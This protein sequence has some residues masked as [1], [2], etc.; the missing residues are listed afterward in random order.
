[1]MNAKMI[2]N[3]ELNGIEVSF[4][5]K[6]EAATLE[7]LKGAGFRWH[8]VK[9]VWYAKNTAERLAIAQQITGED[10]PEAPKAKK[11]TKA[12]TINL[13]NLGENT[14]SL[15]GADLAKAIRED[16]KKRGVTGVTVRARKVT[17][18]TG[19][20]VTI[21]AGAE[22]IASIEEYQ[23]RY[24]YSAFAC[25][26]E[27]SQGVFDGS[28]WIYSNTWEQMTEEER[29]AAYD[30]HTRYYLEKSPSFNQYHQERRN[31]PNMTTDFYN[32]VVAVWK[33]ANQ[34][35]WNHSDSM[36][37]Y[38]DIGY[39]L[40]IDIKMPEGF[41]ARE[42]MTTEEREAYAAEIKAEEERRAA[43]LEQWKREE[44]QRKEEARK[45]EERRQ[46]DEKTILD[47][48]SIIDLDESEQ[49]YIDNLVGGYGK[50]CS[51]AELDEAIT[52]RRGARQDAVI[53]RK[54]IFANREAFDIFGNYLL[55]DFEFIAGK[56]G[57][58]SEDVR[59]EDVKN[60]YNLNT[61]Q[62]ESVKWYMCDCVAV[63]VG[64]ELQIVI[65]PDG[66]NYARYTYRLTE[67]SKITSAKQETE[68]Q[69]TESELLTP[70]YFPE[71]VEDQA[72]NIEIGQSVTIYQCDGWLLN[73]IYAGS[74]TV[75][76]VRPG[77]YAQYNGVYI[78]L[79][80]GNKVNPVFIRNGRNCLIYDGIKRRLPD[81]LTREQVSENMYKLLNADELFPLILDYYGKQG[82]TPIVDTIQR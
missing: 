18:E 65:N 77:S 68:K 54:V 19:I 55:Y 23:T 15:Y 2:I 66:Y 76:A 70:F 5:N 11:A 64:E 62:C 43:E 8:R 12:D 57:T 26:A 46:A 81:D 36:S 9:K 30:S 6:P 49:I 14:P 22:D 75:Q 61:D 13:D 20:T 33:I 50:E 4:E 24:N 17:Y 80:N 27:C 34:W 37:D 52:E 10:I 48:V 67:K 7:A 29:R 82:E 40:D 31:Y 63:Y 72:A 73:N 74:G 42:E 35:N 16:L 60:I 78:D 58:A 45:A 69:R 79:L 38:F 25:D 59:L 47:N 39:F 51:L 41:T 21:K 71:S 32:K 53:T 28:R 1:M 56:G 44:E 3:N